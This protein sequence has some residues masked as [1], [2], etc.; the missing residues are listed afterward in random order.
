MKFTG[1]PFFQHVQ[2][3]PERNE[4]LRF[5][6]SMLVGFA[7]IGLIVAWRTHAF[8]QST[9]VCWGIGAA[10]AVAAFIP[11]LGRVAYLCVYVPTSII[12]YIISHIVLALIFFFVFTPLG[13]LLRLMSKDLLQ[14]RAARG[15]TKWRRVEEVKDASSYYRQF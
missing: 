7:A 13:V 10:L 4:L 8:G 11:V 1:L 9:L 2:W 5:A 6:I 12:G 3:R 14:L 15:Q